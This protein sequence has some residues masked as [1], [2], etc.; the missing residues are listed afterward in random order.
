MAQAS[1]DFV[2]W[3]RREH[4]RLQRSLVVLC[5]DADVAA[6]IA[7]EA[8]ARALA[9]WS[10]VGSMASPGGWTYRVALNLLRRRKRR[11]AMESRVLA[12]VAD[13]VPQI[14]PHLEVWQSVAALPE[15]QRTAVVLRYVAD[16][17]EA[18]IA[19]AMGVTRGTVA[20][21]LLVT[22]VQTTTLEV[23]RRTLVGARGER[24]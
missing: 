11:E 13:D 6:E 18:G 2:E 24:A 10:R 20:S 9:R 14:L 16:L 15:R 5:G 23:A 8:F 21:T 17:P 4:P 7:D 1:S 19:Q 12:A 3:Y 22:S